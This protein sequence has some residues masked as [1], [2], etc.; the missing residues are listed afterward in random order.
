MFLGKYYKLQYQRL[1]GTYILDKTGCYEWNVLYA[2]KK[3]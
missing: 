1:E 3:S 2:D